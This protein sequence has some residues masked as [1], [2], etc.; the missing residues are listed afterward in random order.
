MLKLF[1]GGLGEVEVDITIISHT[2]KEINVSEY[3]IDCEI[4]EDVSNFTLTGSITFFDLSGLEEFSPI[5]GGE[6]LNII[7]RTSDEFDYYVKKFKIIKYPEEEIIN[8]VRKQSQIIFYF[9]SNELLTNIRT[10]ISKSFNNQKISSI[11]ENIFSTLKSNKLIEI[12]ET[13]NSKNY[14]IPYITPFNSIKYL[15]KKAISK[16]NNRCGYVFFENKDGFIFSALETLF[17]NNSNKQILLQNFA[18]SNDNK[19]TGYIGLAEYYKR[20]QNFNLIKDID[21]GNYVQNVQVFSYDT[22]QIIEKNFSILTNI[23]KNPLGSN[24]IYRENEISTSSKIC[25]DDE[26]IGSDQFSTINNFTN[27]KIRDLKNQFLYNTINNNALSIG[28][29]GDSNLTCGQIIEIEFRSHSEEKKINEKLSGFYFIKALRH[30][31]SSTS[32]YKQVMLL[33]KPFYSYD[34]SKLTHQI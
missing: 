24:L 9:S 20:I 22:K 15:T 7:F 12:E 27:S 8:E 4:V 23:K 1:A 3:F 2:K 30:K 11:V 5:I 34:D 25:I 16:K 31:I 13:V 28:I 6:T 18:K 21:K 29:N 26:Y 19:Y 14:V 10:K 17:N 33:V 32:G